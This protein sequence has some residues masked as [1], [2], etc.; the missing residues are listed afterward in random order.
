MVFKNLQVVDLSEY[1][2]LMSVSLSADEAIR[3]VDEKQFEIEFRAEFDVF[4]RR[5][6]A[7]EMNMLKAYSIL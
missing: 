7:L 5:K 6:Q 2:P 3:I 4:T 1:K